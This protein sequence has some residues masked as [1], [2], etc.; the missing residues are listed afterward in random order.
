MAKRIEWIDYFKGIGILLVVYGHVIVG[1]QGSNTISQHNP[2]NIS[3]II[4]YGFHMPL[5][6][7]AS[8]I[9]ADKWAKNTFLLA[10]KQ[11]LTTIIYPYFIWVMIT[12][13]FMSIASKFTNNHQSW[14]E[15][16][17]SP[18]HPFSI[19]WYLYCLFFLFIL[20]Y[21]SKRVMSLNVIMIFS[22]IYYIS[23][24]FLN[25]WILSDVGKYFVFFVLGIYVYNK[26]GINIFGKLN[27]K[28]I[29]IHTIASAI[30]FAIV[31]FIYVYS[32]FLLS[33][34][35]VHIIYLIISISGIGFTL[36]IS[37]LLSRV[38]KLIVIKYFGKISLVIYVS[39]LI[40]QAGARIII[41]KF[42]G[43]KNA[44]LHIIIGTVI[45]MVI[46]IIIYEVSK[47]KNLYPV[48]FGYK[49]KEKEYSDLNNMR[50]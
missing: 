32:Y 18:V 39:H 45:G 42:G 25:F 7:F 16:L 10:V 22:I 24:P 13:S 1:L 5:F 37:V 9:F 46:P 6:F 20:Y 15:L 12:G 31:S 14:S 11:K 17:K 38:K 8:G 44:S 43:I 29:L 36:F 27:N 21:F 19:Y 49:L 33:E 23:S 3:N 41:M 26:K 30:I 47:K 2:Y 34:Y 40:P 48:L 28:N 50:I 35:P 4:I